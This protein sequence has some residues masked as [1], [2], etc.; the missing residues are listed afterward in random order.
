MDTQPIAPGQA[1]DNELEFAAKCYSIGFINAT[2][3]LLERIHDHQTYE[4]NSIYPFIKLANRL[5]SIM[6][7]GMFTLEN[8]QVKF[9]SNNNNNKVLENSAIPLNLAMFDFVCDSCGHEFWKSEVPR[10]PQKEGDPIQCPHCLL[11]K[12]TLL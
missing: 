8:E 9:I 4:R 7:A 2:K 10:Y 1:S 11:T 5:P 3:C 6:E 12:L